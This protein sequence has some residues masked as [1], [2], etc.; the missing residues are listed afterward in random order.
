MIQR[1]K[2]IGTIESWGP[3]FQIK[4]D[5]YIN[6]F[7]PAAWNGI[8]SFKGNGASKDCCNDGDRVPIVQLNE[9]GQLV[10]VNSVNGD[11][12][13][14]SRHYVQSKKWLRITIEQKLTNDKVRTVRII[15]LHK[16][17]QV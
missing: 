8:L 15:G 12:N 4:F 17:L 13:Y 5:L 6:S 16:K 9:I 2:Q 10:F 3:F 11:G 14:N 7:G 1:G